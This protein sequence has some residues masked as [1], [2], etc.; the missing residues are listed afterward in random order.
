MAPFEALYERPCRTPICWTE[1]GDTALLT[2]DLVEET[3]EK[4]R[5]VTQRLETAQSR[6]ASYADKNRRHVEFVVG[7]FVFLKVSPTKGVR[8]FGKKGKLA[9][10]F[11]GPFLITERVGK[12]A[13]R[14][15]LPDTLAGIHP[16]FHISMLRKYVKDD[17]KVL[18]PNVDTTGIT[19]SADASYEV[20]PVRL[21]ARSERK[22]RT[23]VTPMVK[24]LWDASDETN[25]TWE[26]EKDVRH[27]FP[28]LFDDEVIRLLKSM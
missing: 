25:A 10:R 26:I 18:A 2:S 6:Q 27:D 28:H 15:D 9:P 7:D 12:V 19:V 11:I 8:R 14:L 13:Y 1:T 4:I 16:V 24:V 22:L 5:L 3:T 20:E 23:K 21:L 17:R